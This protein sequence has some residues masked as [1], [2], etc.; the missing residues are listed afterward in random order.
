MGIT[1]ILTDSSIPIM[2]EGGKIAS[3]IMNTALF[4]S[5]SGTKTSDINNII[6][7]EMRRYGV[8]PWFK[9]VDNYPYASCIS[10]NEVWL[11][12]MPN[13]T[14]LKKD[15]VVSIDLGV[16]FE[17]HYIDHCW[18]I[19]VKDSYESMDTIREEFNNSDDN[20]KKFLKIGV[21][22]VNSAIERAYP[23]NKV[24]DI[25]SAMQ[26]VVESNGYSVIEG[27][28]G[29]GV[30]YGAHMEPHIPCYGIEGSGKKIKK[31]MGLA[32]EVMYSM[33]NPEWIVDSKD[34]WSIITKDHSKTG[35]FEHTIIVTNNG[36][37][38]LTE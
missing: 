24:G 10:V 18:T 6:E 26:S 5:V 36:P 14:V 32:V 15:D 17:D 12:G 30:G 3:N 19:S 13:D 25:S 27:Y 4:S 29:H 21:Q 34:G 31:N 38:I 11:H 2:R 37:E 1:N 8:K 35:M 33:G 23:R 16:K 22:A 28:G 20:V 9:E 7:E